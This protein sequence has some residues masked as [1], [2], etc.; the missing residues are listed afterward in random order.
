MKNDIDNESRNREN[1]AQK[2]EAIASGTS[3]R[4][5]TSGVERRD[6][7]RRRILHPRRP[8]TNSES[9]ETQETTSR[10]RPRDVRLT[11]LTVTHSHT[12]TRTPPVTAGLAHN[13]PFRGHRG[14]GSINRTPTRRG[15][16][17]RGSSLRH[18]HS[19]RT[20]AHIRAQH[21]PSRHDTKCERAR[22]MAWCSARS[23]SGSSGSLSL[24]WLVFVVLRP[25]CTLIREIPRRPLGLGGRAAPQPRNGDHL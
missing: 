9:Q 3:L 15:R 12:A 22:C 16:R 4:S 21:H 25:P 2:R 17:L 8:I 1:E 19:A 18:R 13:V 6:A 20:R 24:S 5:H 23:A 11:T 10:P 7:S 14:P